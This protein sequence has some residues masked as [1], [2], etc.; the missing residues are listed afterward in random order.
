VF[1][2][3]QACLFAFIYFLLDLQTYSLL[4]G[5]LALFAVVSALMALTQ[6]VNWSAQP[7]VF[8]R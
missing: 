5:A 8:L 3:V 2:T 1:A 7:L 6:R 4:V